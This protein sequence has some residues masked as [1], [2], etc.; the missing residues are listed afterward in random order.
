MVAR[1]T[2]PPVNEI[3]G[4]LLAIGCSIHEWAG[5]GPRSRD[6]YRT[7]LLRSNTEREL[8][9]PQECPE[10]YRRL[11]SDLA[12]QLQRLDNPPQTFPIELAEAG[13]VL[14]RTTSGRPVALRYVLPSERFSPSLALVIPRE[15]DLSAWLRAFLDDVHEL[16][17]SRVP[18]PPPRIA[19][20]SIWYTPEERS[21][22]QRIAETCDHID[23]LRDERQ[24]LEDQLAAASEQA[25]AG[26]R[27]CLW[28][29]GDDLVEAVEETLQELGFV[30][31]NMDAETKP[32]EPKR[33]DLRLT[34]PDRA[35]W[36]AIAEVK[37]YPAG[38]KTSGARQIREFR[39]RYISEE[40][41]APDLTLWIANTYKS[42][43][44]PSSRPPPSNDVDQTSTLIGA[45][46]VQVADL[47]RLWALVQAGDIE[48]SRA[49]RYLID[50]APGL[51]PLPTLNAEI[52]T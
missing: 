5:Y 10:R 42:E 3:R 25:N 37:G 19:D 49:A 45:V 36:E 41:H 28:A 4:H 34:I 16:D 30:V 7:M 39:D 8:S 46:H 11:A 2:S 43:G 9:V 12:Q 27:R 29:D 1:R 50:A 18:Q 47:Y 21:L 14:V 52:G 13:S 24:H 6:G 32:G 38:T 51:W 35:G 26:K 48:Q 33:E 15:A 22:A 17:D 31:R 20:L 40:G 23:R 44:D